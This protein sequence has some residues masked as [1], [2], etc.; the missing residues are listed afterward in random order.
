MFERFLSIA[1]MLQRARVREMCAAVQRTNNQR[2][3]RYFYRSDA[4]DSK[5]RQ[6]EYVRTNKSPTTAER[7]NIFPLTSPQVSADK[8]EETVWKMDTSCLFEQTRDQSTSAVLENMKMKNNR[9]IQWCGWLLLGCGLVA[10]AN[11]CVAT[12]LEAVK[13]HLLAQYVNTHWIT[14]VYLLAG[15]STILVDKVRA[16]FYLYTCACVDSVA[17]FVAMGALLFDGYNLHATGKLR[18][19]PVSDGHT[20]QLSQLPYKTLVAYNAVDMAT[21]LA[22]LVGVSLALMELRQRL[23]RVNQPTTVDQAKGL[24]LTMGGLALVAIGVTKLI[25][26][27]LEVRWLSTLGDSARYLFLN[28]TMD[29]PVWELVHTLTGLLTA[30]VGRN[31]SRL[32]AGILRKDETAVQLAELTALSLKPH[33]LLYA[34]LLAA[35]TRL[36][37][38]CAVSLRLSRLLGC[39]RART[40]LHLDKALRRLLLVLGAGLTLAGLLFGAVDLHNALAGSFHNLFYPGEQKL[41]FYLLPAGLLCLSTVSAAATARLGGTYHQMP[42]VCVLLIFSFH[43]AMFHVLAYLYLST[44]EYFGTQLCDLFFYARHRCTYKVQ[45]AGSLLHFAEATLA[46]LV[47]VASIAGA[48]IFGRLCSLVTTDEHYQE[49][50]YQ[51]HHHQHHDHQHHHH[52]HLHQQQQQQMQQQ[53]QQKAERIIKHVAYAQLAAGVIV[54]AVCLLTDERN[55]L[56]THPLYVIHNTIR[57]TTLSMMLTVL[58]AA[59]LLLA[60][61]KPLHRKPMKT[62]AILGIA[63][64]RIVDIFVQIDYRNLAHL[65]VTWAVTTAAEILALFLQFTT[66]CCSAVLLDIGQQRPAIYELLDKEASSVSSSSTQLALSST[67]DDQPLTNIT[68][69]D[70]AH[71]MDNFY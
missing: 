27:A 56:R 10:L 62:T 7:K 6:T 13:S 31:G 34:N 24:V 69:A 39:P 8:V 60:S 68:T 67:D 57:R 58:P 3:R 33:P 4:S 26:W 28:Y 29:E 45:R 55:P 66:L 9:R 30:A 46:A 49:Q 47:L 40:R 18:W 37:L 41:P 5:C 53:Q 35:G 51:Y 63:L 23:E 59:Q 38:A 32:C 50:Q 12:A 52:H 14:C 42:V 25:L 54:Y 44:N 22:A 11:A 64:V 71:I 15:G 21:G 36:P 43:A 61:G 2:M 70:T 65:G 48:F 1:I 20:Q 16:N 17:C 19:A